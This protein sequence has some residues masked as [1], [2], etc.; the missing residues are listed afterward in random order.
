M[1]YFLELSLFFTLVKID[2]DTSE[3]HIN[4]KQLF[5]IRFIEYIQDK[6]LSQSFL[7]THQIEPFFHNTIARLRIIP[8]TIVI[9]YFG[10]GT[11]FFSFK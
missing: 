2:I 6:L 10:S 8:Q 3:A 4:Q 5:N 11:F 1:F 7:A 9:S